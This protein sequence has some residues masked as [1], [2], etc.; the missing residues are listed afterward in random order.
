MNMTVKS[1]EALAIEA[2]VL[3]DDAEAA[4]LVAEMLPGERQTLR[5]AALRLAAIA[6]GEPSLADALTP[7]R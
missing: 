4:E 7:T 5:A 2:Y 6:A 1:T 3:G